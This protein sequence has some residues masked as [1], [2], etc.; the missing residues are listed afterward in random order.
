MATGD[1]SSSE[2]RERADPA[3]GATAIGTPG[4]H[5]ATGNDGAERVE[6]TLLPATKAQCPRC[7]L[8]TAEEEGHLCARCADV[9][10]P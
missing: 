1:A 2:W 6:I 5:A 9:L 3:T 10:A 7:W 4:T 8:Q